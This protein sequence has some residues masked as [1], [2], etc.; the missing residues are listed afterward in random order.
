MT[1]TIAVVMIFSIPII[2]IV[3]DHF[4]KQTKLKQKM[5]HDELEL[6]KL[7]HENFV[8]ETQKMRLELEQ[9]KL[10]DPKDKAQLL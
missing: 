6:E 8:I 7:K 9:M 2:A 5:I 10:E 3:T 4:Q 1:G